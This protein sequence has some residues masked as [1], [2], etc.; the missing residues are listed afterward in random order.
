M[1]LIESLGWVNLFRNGG[2]AE[3]VLPLVIILP[4]FPFLSL[5]PRLD[6]VFTDRFS[7]LKQMERICETIFFLFSH[8]NPLTD[9]RSKHKR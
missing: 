2:V 6:L 8:A 9:P 1:P 3:M 4:G 5:R 7:E